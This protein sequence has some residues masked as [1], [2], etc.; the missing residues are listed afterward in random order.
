VFEG[1]RPLVKDNHNL[2]K[3]DLSGIPKAARGVP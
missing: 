3:F 1:E 2:G